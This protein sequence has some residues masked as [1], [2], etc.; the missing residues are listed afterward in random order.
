MTSAIWWTQ[1]QQE[2]ITAV[3]RPLLVSASAGAGKTAVLA[4]RCLQR[5]NDP[6]HPVDVDRILVLTYTDAAAEEMHDRI[7]RTLRSA[8]QR[9]RSEHL[10][11]QTLFLDAAWISTFHAF[12]KRILTEH[13]YLLDLDPAFGIVD[14]DQQ[15]ALDSLFCHIPLA[16]VFDPFA[17]GQRVQAGRGRGIERKMALFPGVQ[18]RKRARRQH[19]DAEQERDSFR[20]RFRQPD[21]T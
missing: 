20:L 2:A 12:C 7:A 14:P 13:F 19:Q 9:T 1:S 18:Q 15:H 6:E 11:R 5:I 8:Y 4:Q 17:G 21:F 16:L 3:G 10:R